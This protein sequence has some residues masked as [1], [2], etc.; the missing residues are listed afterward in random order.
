[1]TAFIP[2]SGPAEH[3]L[4]PGVLEYG[5]EQGVGTFGRHHVVGG[6][7]GNGSGSGSVTPLSASLP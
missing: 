7:G 6:L 1:M 4:D 3:D 2:A 5:V